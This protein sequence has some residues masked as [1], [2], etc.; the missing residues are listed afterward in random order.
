[1]G[2]WYKKVG[3]PQWNINH[4]VIFWLLTYLLTPWCRVLLE[5][6]TGLQLVKKFPA[7][8]GTRRFIT[9]LAS[10]RHPSLSWASPI[11]ST[12]PHPTSWRSIILVRNTNSFSDSAAW[13][14]HSWVVKVNMAWDKRG[15]AVWGTRNLNS[16]TDEVR[17]CNPSSIR[18]TDISGQDI[19]SI[20]KR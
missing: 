1:M 7:L 3:F 5:K 8:Y 10:V 16:F 6:P 11:E 12:Y 19:C 18:P 17:T 2:V 15:N 14:V 20:V 4:L 13:L 9:A